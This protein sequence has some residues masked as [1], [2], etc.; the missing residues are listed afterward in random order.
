M[1]NGLQNN[2]KFE[3]VWLSLLFKICIYQFNDGKIRK[4]FKK[5]MKDQKFDMQSFFEQH[6]CFIMG[7]GALRELAAHFVRLGALRGLAVPC[8]GSRHLMF[9]RSA[10]FGVLVPFKKP[11]IL[12]NKW[13]SI[14]IY[15]L[16]KIVNW[17]FFW[18]DIV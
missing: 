5:L 8:S 17:P 15:S 7:P 13:Y 14:K 4:S 16:F 1:F 6:R 10:L 2:P 12:L 11:N 18:L 9:F 3:E